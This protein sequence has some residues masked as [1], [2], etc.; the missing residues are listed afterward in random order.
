MKKILTLTCLCLLLINCAAPETKATATVTN[1]DEKSIAVAKLMK[2]YVDNNFD[3]SILSEDCIVRF[4]NIELKKEDFMGLAPLHHSMFDNISFP[5]G[6]IETIHYHGE[7][8]NEG[9]GETWSNQWTDWTA[10]SK[11]SGE[12][13]TNRSHFNYKWENGKI[14]EVNALF[15]DLWYSKELTAFM[16][17]QQ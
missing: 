6:W 8:W 5:D 9:N 13:H 10:T 14:V 16:E 1:Q 15:S 7:N 4:N 2:G 12:T 11:I 3:G 17:K